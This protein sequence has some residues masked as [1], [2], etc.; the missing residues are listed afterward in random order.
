VPKFPVLAA[1]LIAISAIS[2][3]AVLAVY[4]NLGGERNV[5]TSGAGSPAAPVSDQR[6]ASFVVHD[7]PRPVAEVSFQSADGSTKTLADWRGR[8]VLVNLWATWC[9]PCRHEMPALDR[10]QKRLGEEAFEVV[11]IS[12]D[13]GGFDGPRA[14]FEEIGIE[15]LALYNEKSSTML[16]KLGIVGMPTTLLI[17]AGGQEIGRVA[18]PVEWDSEEAVAMI[19]RLAALGS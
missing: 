3:L 6:L 15:N 13:R 10:L 18:G 9:A 17:D 16:S 2:A 7:S 19:A 8:A 14:F 11:T 4:V 12:L 1:A 5:A